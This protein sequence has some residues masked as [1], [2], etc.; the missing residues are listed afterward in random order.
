MITL[1]SLLIVLMVD[2]IPQNS[3]LVSSGLDQCISDLNTASTIPGFVRG[4]CVIEMAPGRK[5]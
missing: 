5:A 2:G 4:A 3:V 1:Y